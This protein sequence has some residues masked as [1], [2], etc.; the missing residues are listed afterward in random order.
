MKRIVIILAAL[1]ACAVST[2]ALAA[3]GPTGTWETKITGTKV[4]GGHIDG[5]WTVDFTRL[6]YTVTW[7]GKVA[8]HG[9]YTVNGSDMELTDKSG[10]LAC[11]STGKYSFKENG[12]KLILKKIKDSKA[13]AGRTAVLTTHPLTKLS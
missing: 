10:E 1:T 13:C 7:K 4:Q 5:T 12:T 11:P 9:D 2:A 3:G 6:T 8:V